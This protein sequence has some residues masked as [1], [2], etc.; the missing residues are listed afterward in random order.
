L[1]GGAGWKELEVPDI[2]VNDDFHVELVT[3]SEGIQ[4]PGQ[5]EITNYITVGWD[6]PSPKTE[7]TGPF[8]KTRSGL[9]KMG[10]L[11]TTPNIMYEGVRWFIR[12]EGECA[13]LSLAYDDGEDEEWHWTNGNYGVLFAPPSLPF[14]IKDVMIYGYADI[15]EHAGYTSKKFT[16][17]I[18]EETNGEVL[19]Q[20]DFDWS[21]F[22]LDRAKWVKIKVPDIESAGAFYVNV[23]TDSVDKDSCLKI[24]IDYGSRN[25]HSFLSSD[26]ILRPGFSG[27]ITGSEFDSDSANW[28]IRVDGVYILQTF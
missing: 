24:G 28:M 27:E 1:E 18:K 13:P 17:R 4:K 21:L 2:P 20:G 12:A 26:V 8:A 19:W 25:R 5:D 3:V 15:N 6:R 10:T 11:I 14:T 9:S 16:V 23:I 22:D 7:L